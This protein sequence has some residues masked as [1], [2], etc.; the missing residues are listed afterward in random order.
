MCIRDR[1]HAFSWNI[2]YL[3]NSV[4]LEVLGLA[5][6]FNG[7]GSA[8]GDDLTTWESGYASTYNGVDFLTWQQNYQGVL[9]AGA[10]IAVPEPGSWILMLCVLLCATPFGRQ[11]GSCTDRTIGQSAPLHTFQH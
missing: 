4:V 6:D 3:P 2:E 11:I 7:D 5:G 1:P 8:L 10:T 9:N